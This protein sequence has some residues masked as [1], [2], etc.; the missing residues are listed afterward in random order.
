M[1]A[2]ST[3]KEPAIVD[4]ALGDPKWATAMDS[5]HQALTRN[6]TWHL[7]PKPKGK[8][9]IGCKWVYKIKHKVDGSIDR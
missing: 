7:V 2:N 6:H 5:E 1:L 8:N 4:D 3:A 9:V